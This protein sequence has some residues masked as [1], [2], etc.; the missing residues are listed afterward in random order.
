MISD[1]NATN[2]V[3]FLQ[4]KESDQVYFSQD[5]KYPN[6]NWTQ[7]DWEKQRL[8]S[9]ST[10]IGRLVKNLLP[11]DSDITDKE[12]EDF[13]N[14]WK[15]HFIGD[16]FKIEEVSGED[17]R[18]WYSKKNH[19]ILAKKSS[20]GKSCMSGEPSKIFNIYVDNPEV[21]SMIIQRDENGK[22]LSRALVWKTTDDI[23]IL[24][25]IYYT[26]DWNK[27]GVIKFFKEKYSD[28]LTLKPNLFEVQLKNWKYVETGYPYLDTFCYL[29]WK[30]G[31]LS[32]EP[33]NYTWIIKLQNTLGGWSES[34]DVV[35]SKNLKDFLLR[36][37]SFHDKKLNSWM[38]MNKLQKIK[39]KIKNWI[40]F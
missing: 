30:T 23:R 40:D 27:Y 36:S 12:I 22:L 33:K 25:R 31:K 8:V 7:F 18:K 2:T 13:V 35:Y 39:S 14:I 38:P 4:P 9:Q 11:K 15:S 20:L 5:S 21:V 28:G 24:D 16:R 19:N 32:N 34:F 3:N 6:V 17:I 26:H 1:D 37:E 10:K 29:D